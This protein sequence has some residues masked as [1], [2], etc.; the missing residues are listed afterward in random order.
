MADTYL[1][2][3]QMYMDPDYGVVVRHDDGSVKTFR[4]AS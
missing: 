4:P 3:N 2:G 1:D